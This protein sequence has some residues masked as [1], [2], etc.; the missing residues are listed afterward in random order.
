M[1]AAD[2]LNSLAARGPALAALGAAVVV[3]PPLS[4]G[5]VVVI[6]AM[7]VSIVFGQI[8]HPGGGGRR[9]I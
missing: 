3:L 8:G 7:L 4:P 2:F 9:L 1:A 6:A 5:A